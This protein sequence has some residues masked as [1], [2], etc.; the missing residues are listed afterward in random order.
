MVRQ[1]RR[2]VL[3]VV[4]AAAL[5]GCAGVPLRTM[6]RLRTIGADDLL[7]ADPR[8]LGVALEVHAQVRAAAGRSPILDLSLRPV[9][10]GAFPPVVKAL[11]FEPEPGSPRDLGLPVARPTRHWLVYRLAEPSARDLVHA[12]GTIREAREKKRRGTL[13]VGVRNDWIAEVYPAAVGTEAAT[14]VRIKRA[15]GYFELWSGR[16][17]ALPAR[18]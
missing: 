12:Q 8:D 4:A 14:W 1:R 17:P 7:A 2:T 18:T 11:V 13:S 9:E 6:V 10:D 3:A 15:E 5:G 16:V